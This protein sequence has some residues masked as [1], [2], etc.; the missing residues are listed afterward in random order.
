MTITKR[1]ATPA[2]VAEHCAIR[3]RIRYRHFVREISNPRAKNGV[4]HKQYITR[5]VHVEG[6]RTFIKHQL[7]S[8][9][10]A[11]DYLTGTHCTLDGRRFIADIRVDSPYLPQVI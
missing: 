5:R 4:S 2:E 9:L 8:G 6:G 3:P 1:Q 7:P 10:V 11:R